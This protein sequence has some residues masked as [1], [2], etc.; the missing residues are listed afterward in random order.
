MEDSLWGADNIELVLMERPKW[1]SGWGK[2]KNLFEGSL[3]VDIP[4]FKVV[5]A[6][7]NKKIAFFALGTAREL[8]KSV[9]DKE[10]TKVLRSET[11]LKWK[12]FYDSTVFH[13][14]IPVDKVKNLMAGVVAMSSE[15]VSVYDMNT[16]Y[17]ASGGR[18]SKGNTP[19]LS[20]YE[21]AKK[22]EEAKKKLS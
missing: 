9:L 10:N 7:F 14:S 15:S 20:D 19:T 6:S 18:L 13:S 3:I 11:D 4:G 22:I 2:G 16:V 17:I 1:L 8:T 12:I 21:L 5:E